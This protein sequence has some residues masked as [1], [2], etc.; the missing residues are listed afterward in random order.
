MCLLQDI[1]FRLDDAV[2]PKDLKATAI[3]VHFILECANQI[4]GERKREREAET[5]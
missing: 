2:D 3:V 5:Y 1:L 4:G